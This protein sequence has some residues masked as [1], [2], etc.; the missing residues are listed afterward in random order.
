VHD[1]AINEVA[2]EGSL[3]AVAVISK[4]KEGYII[5]FNPNTKKFEESK[6]FNVNDLP[7]NLGYTGTHIICSYKKEY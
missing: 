1:F 2:K 4:K 7:T 6:K 3:H 5:F